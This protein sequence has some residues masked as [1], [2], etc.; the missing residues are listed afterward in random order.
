MNWIRFTSAPAIERAIALASEVFATPGTSSI[1]RCPSASRH[2][3]ASLTTSGLPRM[4][5]STFAAS[6][7][8]LRWKIAAS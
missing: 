8:N 1:S 6:A 3:S 4:K 5:S 2:T 7:S